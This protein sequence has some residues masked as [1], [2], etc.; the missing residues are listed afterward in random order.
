MI[1]VCAVTGHRHIS[2]E[3]SIDIHCRLNGEILLAIT[4]GYTHFISGFASGIDLEFAEIILK[5]KELI[6]NISLEAAIP[7]RYRLE[8]KEPKF[9]ELLSK[10]DNINVICEE[11]K[12]NCYFLRNTYLVEK[13]DRII[14]VFDG[15]KRSG[16]YQTIGIARKKMREIKFINI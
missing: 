5:V 15:R 12:S 8:E 6:P 10:C 13:A 2:P 7:Y 11:K 1:K 14:A 3:K 9:Q 4:D 16:T